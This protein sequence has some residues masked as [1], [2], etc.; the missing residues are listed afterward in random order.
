MQPPGQPSYVEYWTHFLRLVQLAGRTDYYMVSLDLT[1]KTPTYS[2]KPSIRRFSS[3][4]ESPE[5]VE[6]TLMELGT[7]INKWID[8]IPGH[9]KPNYMNLFF[10]SYL[11]FLVVSWNPHNPHKIFF[12]QSAMLQTGLLFFQMRVHSWWIRPGPVSSLNFSALSICANAARSL[13]HVLVEYHQRPDF[14]ML[15]HMMASR[16]A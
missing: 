1:F 7:E 6:K 11:Q 15:P 9:C 16:L 4:A 3:S 10:E 13:I 12:R 8:A 14:V 2:S 5:L